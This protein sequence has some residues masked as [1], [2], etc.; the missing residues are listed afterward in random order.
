MST[1]LTEEIPTD[2]V[3]SLKRLRRK[4]IANDD[5]AMAAW[6]TEQLRRWESSR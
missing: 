4:S 3:E 2:P 1:D 5:I 6:A